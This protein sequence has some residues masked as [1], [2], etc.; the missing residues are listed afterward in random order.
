MVKQLKF[1]IAS[2]EIAFHNQIFI[3]A[4]FDQNIFGAKEAHYAKGSST[5]KSIANL[6]FRMI[7]MIL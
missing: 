5:M 1:S 3:L 4:N 7:E 6:L 2:H